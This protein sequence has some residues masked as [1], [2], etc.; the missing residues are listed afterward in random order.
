MTI[1]NSSSKSSAA[2][3]DSIVVASTV[4]FYPFTFWLC[5]G[6]APDKAGG[7]MV[8][9]EEIA[10]KEAVTEGTKGK[11]VGT[12]GVPAG[13]TAVAIEPIDPRSTSKVPILP[14]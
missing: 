4:A 2:A 8:T 9:E 1:S 11:G 7:G 10:E 12:D 3:A 5:A 14:L 6:A 13:A